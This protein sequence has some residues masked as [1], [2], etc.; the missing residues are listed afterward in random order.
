MMLDLAI[1]DLADAHGSFLA[2]LRSEGEIAL[3]D[4]A[5]ET[6]PD[7]VKAVGPE[8]EGQGK[9]AI[10]ADIFKVVT[11]VKP[12]REAGV[13]FSPMT[14]RSIVGRRRYQGKIRRELKVKFPV[15]LA[16][17]QAYRDQKFLHVGITAAGYLTAAKALG[18]EL[19]SWITRHGDSEGDFSIERT[20]TGI[21]ITVSNAVP[22]A[23]YL[24]DTMSKSGY[25]VQRRA[26]KLYDGVVR[27]WDRAKGEF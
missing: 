17:F 10:I 12:S 16:D 23:Y 20:K 24:P 14:V 3:R 11:P 15:R 7:L 2:S 18:I 25:A 8:T 4:F 5:A 22:W 13:T 19:P 6:L 27:A 1:S 9:A 21:E 26:G